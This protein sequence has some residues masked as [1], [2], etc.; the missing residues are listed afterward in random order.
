MSAVSLA[1]MFALTNA[2]AA[3]SVSLRREIVVSA[4]ESDLH[5]SVSDYSER[6]AARS[7]VWFSR[8]AECDG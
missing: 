1:V 3:R 8:G 6:M 4:R 5:P 2:A 7:R